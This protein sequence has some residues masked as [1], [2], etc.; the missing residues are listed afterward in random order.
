MNTVQALK[1]P[2]KTYQKPTNAGG[3]ALLKIKERCE[4][5]EFINSRTQHDVQTLNDKISKLKFEN[6]TIRFEL[7]SKINLIAEFKQRDSLEK[8]H[9]MTL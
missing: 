4:E 9:D 6:S 7:D 3:H 5:L 8:F 2:L 1:T